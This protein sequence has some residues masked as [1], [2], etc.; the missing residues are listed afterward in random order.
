MKP[1]ID[2]GRIYSGLFRCFRPRRLRLFYEL[3]GVHGGTRILDLGGGRYFWELVLAEGLP[4]PRVTIVNIH[5]P[6]AGAAGFAWVVADGRRLPFADLSFDVVF[7]NSVIEHLGD[8]E[9]QRQLAAEIRRVAPRYFVQTPDVRFPV[10]PHYLAPFLH[11]LPKGLQRLGL[12]FTPRA[13]LETR[14]AAAW[15][16]YVDDLRPLSPAG[17]RALFPASRVMIERL[18]GLPKSILAVKT[19]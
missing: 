14:S 2:L 10:E 19:D 13:A 15:R 3:F 6:P 5:A 18:L 9:S 8:S 7:C 1:R 11:W 16:R 12:P 17:M 4:V